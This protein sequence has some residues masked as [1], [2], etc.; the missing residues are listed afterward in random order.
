MKVEAET[1]DVMKVEAETDDAMNV[2]AET[3]DVTTNHESLF[4]LW[5]EWS[6]WSTC[7]ISCGASPGKRNKHFKSLVSSPG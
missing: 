3:D 4:C 1:D 6:M 7:S 5:T 2:E